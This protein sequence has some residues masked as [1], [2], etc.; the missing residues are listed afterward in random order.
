VDLR[1]FPKIWKAKHVCHE[2]FLLA[3]TAGDS[4]YV[5]TPVISAQQKMAKILISVHD[6]TVVTE[7]AVFSA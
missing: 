6:K 4:Q 1:T 7:T 2:A 5:L 3:V